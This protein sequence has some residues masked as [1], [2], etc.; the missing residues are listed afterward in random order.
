MNNINLNTNLIRT[1]NNIHIRVKNGTDSCI[2]F[3]HKNI[4]RHGTA[5]CSCNSIPI[6]MK[7]IDQF[8]GFLV[9]CEYQITERQYT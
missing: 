6:L 3:I 7:R 1:I 9:K 4:G 8:S 5:F 2:I